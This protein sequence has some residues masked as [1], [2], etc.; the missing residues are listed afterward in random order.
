MLT[1]EKRPFSIDAMIGQKMIRTDMK[2]RSKERDFP[3]VMIFE[4][5][6]GTGKTTLASIVAALINDSNSIDRGDFRD[7]N[8]ESPSSQDILRERFARD[9][10]F[11]DASS[12]NKEEMLKLEGVVSAA[13]MF[14]RKK[15]IVIDEAQ[16]LTNA[17]KG[18]AL[19]LLEKKRK[20]A[21]IILCTMDISR[22]DSA[23]RSRGQN[24]KFRAPGSSEIAEL[25][26]ELIPEDQNIP[27]E[28]IT[29][30]VFAI[31]ESC[32]GSV[33]EAVQ[34]LE[35][36]LYSEAF[37][38]QEIREEFGFVSQKKLLELVHRL[39]DQDVSVYPE[40]IGDGL[41]DFFFK[42]LRVL[43]DADALRTTGHVDQEWKRESTQKIS[44]HPTFDTLLTVFLENSREPFFRDVIFQ[45]RLL[46]YF[47]K[48]N[49]QK[50]TVRRRI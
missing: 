1:L 5:P 11:Y 4:G 36:C 25:L 46:Q 45:S 40:I 48:A 24:Y 49:P 41:K 18:V 29:Q 37:T 27:E 33:R 21:H 8:P 3:E 12:M 43:V 35:R 44:K 20:N 34:Y 47:R 32:G 28:F 10:H 26:L 39:L 42:A 13:P 22:F 7:P 30:G 14:D 38:E 31:A 17:G 9:V 15:I 16:E 50:K 19:R 6:S 23:V 2:K